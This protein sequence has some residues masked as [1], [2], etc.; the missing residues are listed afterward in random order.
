MDRRSF[1][2]SLGAGVLGVAG[3][4]L[5]GRRLHAAE[6]VTDSRT[7]FKGVLVD[8]TRCIGCRSCEEACA[9]AH[10]LPVPDTA[11]ESVFKAKRDTSI[12]QLTVVNR[13]ETNKGIIFVKKQCMH[14]GQPSC[15]AA[16]I[17]KAMKKHE[18]GAV[19]WETNCMGC[20][21]CMVS[22]PFDIPKFEYNSWNPKIL[23]C[24]LCWEQRLAKGDIPACVDACPAET[25]LFG[26]KRELVAEARR[27]IY[28]EPKKYVDYIY[29]ENDVGGTS[30]IYLSAVPFEQIGFKMDLGTVAYPEYTTGFLYTEPIALI[31]L[32][33]F[34]MGLSYLTRHGEAKGKRE[35]KR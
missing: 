17:V 20:R 28:L 23:K 4:A 14:C 6:I 25:L 1:L 7:E 5:V 16:C 34:L 27:R 33:A 8:T 30:W 29:G 10:D 26:K 31:L 24:N 11:D 13:F 18:D 32:P 19:T 12:T 3:T 21:Y 22:C 15:V 2:K 9:A 35:G